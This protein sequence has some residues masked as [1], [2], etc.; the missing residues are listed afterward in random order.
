MD[1]HQYRHD[2]FMA[3]FAK[4]RHENG[5][6]PDRGM[7][8]LFA[9]KLGM[10]QAFASQIKCKTKPIGENL[11]RRIEEAMELPH[12]WMDTPHKPA[13]KQVDPNAE[14][15][16]EALMTLYRQAPE[17]AQKMIIDIVREKVAPKT[18]K[19]QG[20]PRGRRNVTSS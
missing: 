4:F 3:L 15:L 1:S 12:G 5:H 18:E 10:S 7:L 14:F 6:L 2:N 16:V 13:K 20:K 8:K 11:A 9:E 19:P 17:E